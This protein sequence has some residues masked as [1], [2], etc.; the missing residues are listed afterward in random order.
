[1]MNT[2]NG[3]GHNSNK[4]TQDRLRL[5]PQPPV[6]TPEF[7]AVYDALTALYLAGP[8]I[9]HR[10]TKAEHSSDINSNNNPDPATDRLTGPMINAALGDNSLTLTQ[11]EPD[12]DDE[13]AA[14]PEAAQAEAPSAAR[15][16]D[17]PIEPQHSQHTA[18]ELLLLAHLPVNAAA[19]A[20]QYVRDLSARAGTPVA[21]IRLQSGCACVELV[22]SRDTSTNT[23]GELPSFE[24]AIAEAARHTQRWVLRVDTSS[25]QSASAA[26]DIDELTLLTASDDAAIVGG[27]Q[28]LK[29]LGASARETSA[30]NVVVVA[31]DELRGQAAAERIVEAAQSFLDRPVSTRV[32]PAKVASFRAP[33][34]LYSGK[35]ETSPAEL[36]ALVRAAS[37]KAGATT[38]KPAPSRQS[39]AARSASIDR[40]PSQFRRRGSLRTA[41]LRNM[42][43]TTLSLTP[44]PT[45][46]ES[47]SPIFK[48]SIRPTWTQ[49][50]EATP[51]PVQAHNDTPAETSTKPT[52]TAETTLTSQPAQPATSA[53][54]HTKAPP[55]P[56]ERLAGDLSPRDYT[57]PF[58][59]H[60]RLARDDAGRLHAL[61]TAST[62]AEVAES[63]RDLLIAQA[64]A[65][66]HAQLLAQLDNKHQQSSS[67]SYTELS[68]IP[69]VESTEQQH[70]PC[71]MHLFTTDPRLVARLLDAPIA[72]HALARVQTERGP[73][74]CAMDLSPPT[75]T[76][77][78]SSY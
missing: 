41:T 8:P 50:L 60:I 40:H 49:T 35:I 25:E 47:T 23:T 37:E 56:L 57:C 36:A 54:A 78:P 9:E 22:G 52:S 29:R 27:Y 3:R 74:W 30:V 44:A 17:Q 53:T 77:T 67:A 76:P 14:P 38:A 62:H 2:T 10:K 64:W 34:L 31:T 42:S 20:V 69:A 46:R 6:T 61:T 16:H 19:W 71:A 5:V 12:S 48:P 26:R 70:E 21:Y 7:D 18:I 1:M 24:S 4:P 66:T 32:C 45:P 39:P 28:S 43:A 65:N 15:T 73:A 11:H 63:I 55:P 33:A 13:D 51:T 75:P 68:S 59:T 58:A 72:L